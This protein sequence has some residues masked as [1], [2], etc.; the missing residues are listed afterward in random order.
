M[1]LPTICGII[2]RRL[3]INYR[4]DPEIVRPMLPEPLY[5]RL[6]NGH[7][8]AGSCLIRLSK[9]RP[10]WVP[11]MFGI[12]SEG[13]AHRISMWWEEDGIR[14]TGVFVPRRDSSSRINCLLGGRLFPGVQHHARFAVIESGNQIEINV[15]DG[16]DQSM[17]HLSARLCNEF[18]SSSIFGSLEAASQFLEDDRVGISSRRQGR[19]F[20]AMELRIRQWK[21]RPVSVSVVHSSLFDDRT[22]FPS[23][24]ATLDCTVHMT[25]I[26]HE[27]LV[28]PAPRNGAGSPTG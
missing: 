15:R 25:N 21:V 28:A 11:Q 16:E 8:I 23:G 14:K 17:I 19:G 13:T 4:V 7:A 12:S 2:V 9:L 22:R 10:T 26:N 6:H 1:K 24:S 3:L 18:P 27:W 20:D 5:P